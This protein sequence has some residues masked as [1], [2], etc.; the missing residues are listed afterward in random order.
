MEAG[1][2]S[3]SRLLIYLLVVLVFPLVIAQGVRA[4]EDWEQPTPLDPTAAI[5][6]HVLES[7]VHQPLPEQFIW[8]TP[9]RGQRQEGPIFFRSTFT[10][11]KKPQRATLYVAGPD[12]AAVYLNG[13]LAGNFRQD[14]STRTRPPVFVVEVTS[15]LLEGKNLLALQISGG[16]RLAVKIVP[17][18]PQEFAP[19]LMASGSGWKFRTAHEEGWERASFDDGSWKPA[20]VLGGIEGDI[21]FWQWNSDSGMYRWPGYDGI[22]PFLAHLR[23]PVAKVTEVFAGMGKFENLEALTSPAGREF[24]VTPPPPSASPQEYPSLLLDFGRETNGRLEVVSASDAPMRLQIGY[25]ESKEESQR[26][27]Y[28]GFD[29]L[30]IPPRATVHGPKSSFRYAAL[31]FLPGPFPL[32]FK[33]I[34]LDAIYYPVKYQGSFESSDPLLN[35]IWAI[36]AYTAHLC[37]QDYV[38]DAPKRDRSPWMGDMHVSG[39]VIDTVFADRFLM[40]YTMDHLIQAA[41]NPIHDEVNT[42]PGYSAFWVMGEADY[43][44]HVGDAAYLHS[45]HDR[46]VQ[47]LS[48]METDLDARNLFVNP[49]RAWGFVDWSPDYNEDTPESRRA[50]DL[51]FFKAFSEGAWL[52]REAGDSTS[53]A[54][55]QARADAMK[56][57][58]GMYLLDAGTGTF[59]NR[60]Q[61]NAMAIFSGVAGE[62]ET[63]AIWDRVLSR[64]RHFVITPYYNFYVIS[65]MAAAGHRRE[66]LEEVRNYWGGMVRQGATST[67]EAYDPTWPKDDFHSALQADDRRGYFISL[68]HGWS[69][70]ATAWL[71]EQVLGI[72][73]LAA[74]FR[75]VAIRPDLVD[76]EWA[77][78]AEPT[79]HGLL[80]VD[81]RKAPDGLTAE[82]EL[83]PG[84]TARVSMPVQAGQTSVKVNGKAVKGSPAENGARRVVELAGDA[85]YHLGPDGQ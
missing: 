41:G 78:G 60:H 56:A 72:Q 66:A 37:M 67:W 69:S 53:A 8:F 55:F 24:S 40:Q 3:H 58:A 65:A 33:A 29:E 70:G 25:G 47:L 74:G 22:S 75:E 23:L 61:T 80:K 19:A 76:L 84:V 20:A 5:S 45:I 38:W 39:R 31:H 27:P 43:Y 82:I 62:A 57:A 2:R 17:R 4:A 46:L 77:R 7:Q 85:A 59:G 54:R 6:A 42:F 16:D 81:Y 52:L 36:G 32:K 34:R 1:S 68:A 30:D 83:P 64:P 11:G 35:R 44:R 79:P 28:L 12:A 26:E 48:F 14:P 49:R 63:A 9:D 18:G 73:P 10:L 50:I 71:T 13:K 51:E 21:D 15:A